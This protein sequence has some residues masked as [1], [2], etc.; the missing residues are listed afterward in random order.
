VRFDLRPLA[1]WLGLTGGLALTMILATWL[2]V[3]GLPALPA[4][5]LGFLVPNADLLWRRLRRRPPGE[6]AA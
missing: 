3:S 1:T 4:L 2:D 6:S 5:S